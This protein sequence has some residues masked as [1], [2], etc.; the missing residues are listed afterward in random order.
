[1]TRWNN[2]RE[3]V[4]EYLDARRRLGYQMKISGKQLLRFARFADM[5]E[6]CKILT[7]DVAV[8]WA[9]TS[10]S[11]LNRAR[12]LEMIRGLAKYCVLFEP[13]TQIPPSRLFGPAH[14]RLTP[15]I[16]TSQEIS[17]LMQAAA[18][19]NNGK[20]LR[21]ATIQNLFG[22]LSAT[23]LRIS[24][25][26]HLTRA[27]VDFEE[28]LIVVKETKFNKSRYVP[29]HPTAIDALKD[30]ARFRDNLT[31][32]TFE[33]D[34]FF[35]LDDGAPLNYRQALYSFQ[36]IRRQMSWRRK[37]LPRIHDLRHTFACNRLLSWY[38]A[39]IDV[40][41]AI[42]MLSVYLGH[43]KVTDTYWYLTGIP[44][45]MSIAAERFEHYSGGEK[46]L[47]R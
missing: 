35:T 20:G 44:S 46:W 21:P 36:T 13:K 19:L 25:A 15:Y 41:N 16:Y 2:M 22:L 42:L 8:E 43:T 47:S 23:G 9:C 18:K 30:Y 29:L 45:L 5:H 39:G 38:E 4:E 14:R 1:M 17:G 31:P 27:D 28:N 12:R 34:A 10:E 7:I 11:Q 24:E 32:Q 37:R 26:L 40:N 3:Q 33:L 6:S